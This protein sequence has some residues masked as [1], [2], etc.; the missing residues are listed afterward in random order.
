MRIRVGGSTDPRPIMPTHGNSTTKTGV[1][2]LSTIPHLV[3]IGHVYSTVCVSCT[4]SPKLKVTYEI[5]TFRCSEI[6][7][8]QMKNDT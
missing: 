8:C 2:H 1:L 5:R 4:N 3:M 6:I 7:Q